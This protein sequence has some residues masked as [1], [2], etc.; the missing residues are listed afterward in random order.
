MTT[1]KKRLGGLKNIYISPI[2]PVSGKFSVP[3]PLTGAKEIDATLN[4]DAVKFYSDNTIDYSD[5]IFTGGDGTLKVS[6]LTNAETE[7]LFGATND[8]KGN[9]T[10]RA[11]D[12]S[13]EMAILF[14]RNKLGTTQKVLYC[15]YA[16]KFAPSSITAKTTEDKIE[17]ELAELKFSIRAFDDNA[18]YRTLDT[19]EVGVDATQITGW[20]TT[21]PSILPITAPVT[22]QT[23][24]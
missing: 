3:V 24:K 17:E 21:A 15:I 8:D 10:V 14:E 12:V 20:Y 6:G 19:S 13:Q 7:L 23:T 1:L 2:D 5:Y 11:S 9:L 16:C 4:Y 18:I 22:T